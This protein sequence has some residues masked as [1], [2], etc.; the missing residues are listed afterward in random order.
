[1]SIRAKFYIG[2][3]TKH[4]VPNKPGTH[5]AEVSLSGVRGNSGTP[6][7]DL[8]G[9][10]TPSAHGEVWFKDMA[11]AEK[12]M[13]LGGHVYVDFYPE[14]SEPAL[15]ADG[16]YV[17]ANCERKTLMRGDKAEVLIWPFGRSSEQEAEWWGDYP[18]FSLQMTIAPKVARDFFE[19][20]RKYVAVFTPVP[21]EA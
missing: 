6:E 2:K 21:A 10:A 20:D 13:P 8:F 4:A 5:L 18:R 17:R 9:S 19:P 14:G 7:D 15:S 16:A 3:Q 11:I 1:M 12:V